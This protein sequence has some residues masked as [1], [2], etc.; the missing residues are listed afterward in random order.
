[1]FVM[2]SGKRRRDYKKVLEAVLRALP[3]DPAVERLVIDFEA[4]MWRAA[5]QVLPEVAKQGCAF[6]W[7]QAVWRKAQEYG[8]AI[9]YREEPG[10]RDVCRKLLTLPLL[11]QE[12]I[13]GVFARLNKRATTPALC[14][15]FTY[16]MHTWIESDLWPPSA[17][18]QFGRAIRTN[19]DVEGWHRRLN[20]RAK[21]GQLNLY[22]LTDLLFQEAQL[23]T[24]QARLVS[25]RKLKRH[26]RV[27]YIHYQARLFKLWNEYVA[28][29][30]TIDQLVAACAKVHGPV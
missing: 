15:L 14:Q 10:T 3:D 8:L 2:M 19:N 30:R 17:W 27:T 4:A 5:E 1:M 29:E 24:I 7:T 20:E 16:T 23:V 26:Q 13:P 22:L 11:P 9:A 12:E 25:E 6:H 21:N 28:E 18:S